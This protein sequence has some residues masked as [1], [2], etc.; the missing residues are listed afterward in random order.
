MPD[1]IRSFQVDQ[2]TLD[3]KTFRAHLFKIVA[4]PVVIIFVTLIFPHFESL[5][6]SQL[7]DDI[8]T[9]DAIYLNVVQLEKNFT[10]M[11]TAE[12]GFVITGDDSF[13]DP[14]RRSKVKIRDLEDELFKKIAAN[15]Q[16]NMLL[17]NSLD[18]FREW[19]KHS[20]TIIDNRVMNRQE[21]AQNMTQQGSDKFT[22]LRDSLIILRNAVHAERTLAAEKLQ[23]T[24][25]LTAYLEVAVTLIFVIFLAFVITR[26]LRDLTRS[27]RELLD[28]NFANT[29][30]IQ[31]ASKAK[32]LFL[33]NMSHEI[34]TPL[35][36]IMGFAELAGQSKNLDPVA[37][38]HISFIRRNSEHLLNLIDDLFDL[39]KVTADKIDIFLDDINLVSF[40]D[41][42]KNL[43]S[44]RTLDKRIQ[45]NI[46]IQNEIPRIIKSDPVRVKQIVSNLVGNAIKFSGTGGKVEVIFAFYN[47]ELVI[48]VVDQGIGIDEE[49][50]KTIFE[51]FRQADAN[52]SR[53]FGGAGLGLSISK[54][55]AQ[56]LAG[57]VTL[58]QSKLN[59]GSHF[60]FR[61]P[62]KQFTKDYLDQEALMA[63][64][65][66]AENASIDTPSE[67][68]DL[69][70][71]N[72]LLA[73]DSK[74]NQILFKIFIESSN[75]QLTIVENGADAVR[76]ALNNDYDLIL[77]DI[78]MP[79]LD[80]YEAVRI[81]RS[82]NYEKKIIALTA[83]TMKGEREKCLSAG[84]DGYL[85]KPVSQ[86][87]LLRTIQGAVNELSV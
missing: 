57:D 11:E 53:Q 85:S 46:V 8:E 86:L 39:S 54:K 67:R 75:A 77:M 2:K 73:E 47:E 32:D 45:L 87:K 55:L 4:V 37:K 14:S 15:F 42:L 16:L 62:V 40:V 35:G 24:R 84:F 3:D 38:N 83:H 28:A 30:A 33:A 7:R 71:K 43:Y 58:V 65:S 76:Q 13:L 60:R 79:G 52:H 9:Y 78:Q 61:L 17:R 56:I 81:L 82:S 49:S 74:E 20:E 18:L 27:Y 21:K 23:K 26:Q 25:R 44:S 59:E 12:R 51:A 70:Q 72:I 41:D 63:S 22:Q 29:R 19:Q 80:G 66:D 36:A 50:Q 64:K 6:R 31:Q 34:R 5:Y 68:I 48:D 69:S 10:D 1:Q